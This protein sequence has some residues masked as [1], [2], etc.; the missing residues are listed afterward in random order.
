MDMTG[1]L[2][3]PPNLLQAKSLQITLIMKLGGP[4][5]PSGCLK[6][7][8]ISYPAENQRIQFVLNF[9]FKPNVERRCEEQIEI[10]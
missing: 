1:P 5:S 2:H 4:Q 7:R 3:A 8:E 10:I 9:F 6:T